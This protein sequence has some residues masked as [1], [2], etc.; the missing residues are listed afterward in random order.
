M[1]GKRFLYTLRMW[2]MRSSIARTAYLK[3]KD[4]FFSMGEH[5]DVMNR[6]IPLY[7]KLIKLGNNVHIA[8]NVGFV[9]HD[10]VDKML[11]IHPNLSEAVGTTMKSDFKEKV[12]CIEIGDNVFI[13]AGTRILYDVRIGSNCIIGAGSLVNKDIPDNSVAAGV[14]AKVIGTFAEFVQ[15]RAK[16]TVYPKEYSPRGENVSPELV[17]FLWQQFKEGREGDKYVSK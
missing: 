15:K 7:A 12:G 10:I 1:K 4:I 8:S 11:N 16:D 5:C 2:M 14:P 3:E 17:A 13:G 9:T 6:T